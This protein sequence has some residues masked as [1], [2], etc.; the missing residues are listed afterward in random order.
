[1]VILWRKG[2]AFIRCDFVAACLAAVNPRVRAD[3][4]RT[5][6]VVVGLVTA[7][8]EIC[9]VFVLSHYFFRLGTGAGFDGAGR[10]IVSTTVVLGRRAASRKVMNSPVRASRP[11]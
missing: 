9:G 7:L 1:M 4:T 3:R 2:I 11:T 5:V 6:Q 8:R 10:L